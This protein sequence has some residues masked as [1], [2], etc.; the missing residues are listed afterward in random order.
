MVDLKTGKVVEASLEGL[1]A[2][3]AEAG[4]RAAHQEW[5]SARTDFSFLASKGLGVAEAGVRLLRVCM[6]C[7]SLLCQGGRA[8]PTANIV[9][10]ATKSEVRPDLLPLPV[11]EIPPLGDELLQVLF[12]ETPLIDGAL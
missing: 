5:I 11:P 7:P 8:M 6:R 3:W 9:A 12:A 2:R 10:A 1:E 4:R